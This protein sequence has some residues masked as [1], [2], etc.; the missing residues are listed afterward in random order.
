MR[1]SVSLATQRS[2][3]LSSPISSTS[4]FW[5]PS[6]VTKNSCADPGWPS[7]LKV[8]SIMTRRIA[9]FPN[10]GAH[11]IGSCH[12]VRVPVLQIPGDSTQGTY[13]VTLVHAS[14]G[15]FTISSTRFS[16]VACHWR[17]V[18]VTCQTNMVTR[19]PGKLRDFCVQ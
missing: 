6:N 17:P 5:N 4:V 2:F 16:L 9:G 8:L 14:S 13:K 3:K 12:F 10:K 18:Q 19:D 15:L 1:L 7:I 11:M